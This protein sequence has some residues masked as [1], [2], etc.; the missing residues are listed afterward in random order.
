[1]QAHK[2]DPML[3]SSLVLQYVK[4]SFPEDLSQHM[5][6]EPMVPYSTDL[7]ST[8]Y[9]RGNEVTLDQYLSHA[10][11]IDDRR[12]LACIDNQLLINLVF[13]KPTIPTFCDGSNVVTILTTTENEKNWVVRALEHKHFLE[14]NSQLHYLPADP[15]YCSFVSLPVV[16]KYNN[17]YKFDLADR[18]RVLDQYVVNTDTNHWYDDPEKFV[19][20]DK[21]HNLNNCF[22]NLS[23][24]LDAEK[25]IAEVER[26]FDHFHLGKTNSKL[27]R[28]MHDVW[29]SRQA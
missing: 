6:Q 24:I 20:Y 25:L 19:E 28:A 5:K 14:I 11:Q 7:Y 10:I 2:Q 22:I 16:L 1:M 8:R 15:D 4:R 13:H 26:I 12:L 27:I 21:E 3:F 17:P 29:F 9:P 18:E 23:D